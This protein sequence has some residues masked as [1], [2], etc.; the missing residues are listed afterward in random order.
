MSRGKIINTIGFSLLAVAFAFSL[1]N[2]FSRTA[3][4]FG[5]ERK[6]IRMAHWRL[7]GPTIAGYQ[8]VAEAYMKRH[9]DVIIEQ[10]PVPLRIW[11]MWVL[12]RMTGGNPPD[13]VNYLEQFVDDL[14]LVR[15]FA[16]MSEYIDKPNPYNAGTPLEG[17]PW[18]R[19]FN[20]DLATAP[21]FNESLVEFYSL[22]TSMNTMRIFVNR[23]LL[24]R[25]AGPGARLPT[26]FRGFLALAK[27]TRDFSKRENLGIVPLAGSR[28]RST[29]ALSRLFQ[30]LTQSVAMK[31]DWNYD[32][33]AGWGSGDAYFGFSDGRWS[34]RDPAIRSALAAIRAFNLT[35]DPGFMQ[36]MQDEATFRFLQ[37]RALMVPVFSIDAQNLMDLANFEIEILGR[38]PLPESDDAEFGRGTFGAMAESAEGVGIPFVLSRTSRN[39]ETA[40]DFLQFLTSYEGSRI[41]ITISQYLSPIDGVPPPLGKEA[42][43]PVR[44]GYP[45]GINLID[46]GAISDATQLVRANLHVLA[47]PAGGV[48]AFIDEVEGDFARFMKD[49]LAR[50]AKRSRVGNRRNDSLIAAYSNVTSGNDAM[51]FQT[52]VGKQNTQEAGNYRMLYYLNREE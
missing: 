19:T 6:V 16:P 18:R 8:A 39:F 21:W 17:V 4:R 26:D 36:R 43:A 2:V 44:D 45:G 52:L 37:G 25:I 24:T 14:N 22:P 42:F 13:L 29:P 35:Q 48:D 23:D 11:P 1:W 5:G 49:D 7:E 3:G 20:G 28:D 32:N 50:F 10:T 51:R 27:V 31:C 47:D 41:F 34:L 30:G 33:G 9:P 38:L 15:H 40:L 46:D 12:S